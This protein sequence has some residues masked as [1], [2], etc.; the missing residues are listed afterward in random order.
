MKRFDFFGKEFRCS[1]K[2]DD[3]TI[4]LDSVCSVKSGSRLPKGSGFSL[5]KTLF[6][7]FRPSD[8][9]DIFANADVLPSLDLELFNRLKRY[10]ISSDEVIVSIVGTAGKLF[11][12]GKTDNHVIMTSNCA[13]ILPDKKILNPVYL[14]L[15]MKSDFVSKQINQMI[16]KTTVVNLAIGDIRKIRLKRLP[17]VA[18]Q[19]ELVEKFYNVCRESERDKEQ[20]AIMK[21]EFIKSMEKRLGINV[22]NATG[23]SVF[24]DSFSFFGNTIGFPKDNFECSHR[25]RCL[26]EIATIRKGSNHKPGNK[27]NIPVIGGGKSISSFCSEPNCTGNSVTVGASGVAGY[28]GFH[29]NDIYATD[30]FVIQSKDEKV[31]L[32]EFI[33]CIMQ[34][35]QKRIYASA[36]GFAQT[37]IYM[38]DI[39]DIQIPVSGME[40]Q[41]M[42][43]KTFSE[44]FSETERLINESK[45]LID[46]FF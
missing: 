6:R 46:N 29:R 3:E 42:I 5:N 30:C 14:M 18:E 26:S 10:E 2:T 25:S 1:F 22:D 40:E 23:N 9:S 33:Y 39:K 8:A 17:S 44:T 27:G 31:V 28:V 43:I 20:S 35:F 41:K 16:T 36:R 24:I 21:T 11:M 37:H 19:N 45:K 4:S 15:M 32:T 38:D 7:Y 34:M 12:L 13:A